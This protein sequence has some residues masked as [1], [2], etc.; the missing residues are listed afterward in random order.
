V[1][2]GAIDL[3]DHCSFPSED[4]HLDGEVE[5]ALAAEGLLDLLLGEAGDALVD[6]TDLAQALGHLRVELKVVHRGVL[7]PLHHELP[8]GLGA[9]LLEL[10]IEV[11]VLP[12]AG[13]LLALLGLGGK[14]EEVAL[15]LVSPD[16]NTQKASLI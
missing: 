15:G 16:G 11:E 13:L 14:V 3:C 8:A 2:I 5:D 1:R 7:L 12:A 6:L 4:G 10:V 9:Q